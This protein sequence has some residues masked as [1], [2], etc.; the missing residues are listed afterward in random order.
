MEKIL[1]TDAVPLWVP[2]VRL[3]YTTIVDSLFPLSPAEE[4]V[5]AMGGPVAFRDLPRAPRC[6]IPEACSVFA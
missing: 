1:Y 5:L 3:F 6:S 4:E 2:L